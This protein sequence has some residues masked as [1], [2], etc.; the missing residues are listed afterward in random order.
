MQT[1]SQIELALQ[2]RVLW[3]G[4]KALYRG[5]AAGIYALDRSMGKEIGILKRVGAQAEEDLV[6]DPAESHQLVKMWMW[7]P[8]LLLSI[9][10]ICVVLGVEVS[11]SQIVSL[12]VICSL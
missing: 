1:N 8:D 9:I 5:I 6:E 12:E 10:C 4:F 3:F 2:W 7:L 11:L